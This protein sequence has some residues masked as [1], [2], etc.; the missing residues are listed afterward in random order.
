MEVAAVAA[1]DLDA[2]GRLSAQ[3]G[4]ARD[5]AQVLYAGR[6][7]S[8]DG[9]GAVDLFGRLVS[10]PADPGHNKLLRRPGPDCTCS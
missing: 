4:P 2:L 8:V 3:S 10:G 5:A 1:D 9:A 6:L 7:L